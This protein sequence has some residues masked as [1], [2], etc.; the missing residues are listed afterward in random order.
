MNIGISQPCNGTQRLY[1]VKP[2]SHRSR[3]TGDFNHDNTV[4]AADYVV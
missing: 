2:A 3:P 4:D 1:G